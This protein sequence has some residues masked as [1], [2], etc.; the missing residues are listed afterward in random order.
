MQYIPPEIREDQGEIDLAEKHEIPR[1]VELRDIKGD[2]H[3]H[4][5]WSDGNN[6]IRRNGPGGKGMRAT[7]T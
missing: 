5:N 6:T 7:S 2:F 3:A 4:S 1:L